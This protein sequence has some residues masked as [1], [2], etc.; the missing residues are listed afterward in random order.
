MY[1][2]AHSQILTWAEII[3]IIII[4]VVVVVV[5]VARGG[6]NYIGDKPFMGLSSPSTLPLVFKIH[7]H[8]VSGSVT[9][10]VES[11]TQDVR[12]ATNPPDTKSNLNPNPNPSP[13]TKQHAIVSIQLNTI[14]RSTYP[15]KFTQDTLLTVCTTIDCNC[16]IALLEAL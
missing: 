7:F 1:G 4:I 3:I 2:M 11:S 10:T 6:S 14:T 16:H 5:V 12:L 9:M 15:E 8:W 13:T